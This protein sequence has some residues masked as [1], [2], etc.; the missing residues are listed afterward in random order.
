MTTDKFSSREYGENFSLFNDDGDATILKIDPADTPKGLIS[1]IVLL[2]NQGSIIG[3]PT[4]TVYGLGGNAIDP[5]V[6]E[7]MHRLKGRDHHKPFL[8]L[9]GAREEINP[10]VSTI[11]AYSKILMDRFWPGPLTLI[12]HASPDLPVSLIQQTGKIALWSGANLSQAFDRDGF[13]CSPAPGRKS[14]CYYFGGDGCL[15]TRHR[16]SG[17]WFCS[18]TAAPGKQR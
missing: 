7:R 4:E 10:L 13:C 2:L 9:V 6:I 12:F 15:H 1:R 16:I 8:V 17:I 14:F 11:P 3:Y 5:I 18:A